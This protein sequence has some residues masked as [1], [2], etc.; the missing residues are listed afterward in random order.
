MNA[1]ILTP[2]PKET[3]KLNGAPNAKGIAA[4]KLKALT[5]Y[6]D[7]F[8]L[9]TGIYRSAGPKACPVNGTGLG[10]V[11]YGHVESD[12]RTFIDWGFDYLKYDWCS[13]LAN[14]DKFES[15]V[16]AQ[17]VLPVKIA[18]LNYKRNQDECR[19]KDT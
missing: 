17:S 13:Y 9:Q 2:M 5:E 12:A 3:P 1:Y 19:F 6:I 18:T 15:M 8:G 10:A 11:S 7:N 16:P 14:S 4:G